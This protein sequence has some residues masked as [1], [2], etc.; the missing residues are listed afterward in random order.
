V[1]A[2]S[3][4]VSPTEVRAGFRPWRE[5][6]KRRLT[7]IL[8][9]VPAYDGP[10]S[11][12][13]ANHEGNV[14]QR[15]DGR[16]EARLSYVDNLTG[17][18]KRV[19]VYGASQ[20]GARDEL[21]KVR[22]RIAADAPVR[23]S[24]QGVAT[25]LLKWRT[26]TLAVSDRAPSTRSLYATLCK[27]HLEPEP[28]GSITL[29]R[30]RPTDIEAL[31][32][33]LR[34][35]GLSDSTIRSVYVVLRAAL[36]AAVRD[37]HLARN[38]AAL[39][40]R[41]AVEQRETV[42]LVADEVTALL[43]AA[44]GSRYHTALCLILSTGM[45]RGETLA[46]RWSDID[47][48]KGSAQIARTVSRVDGE[49]VFTPPKSK[50]ARRVP[51]SPGVVAMLKRHRT[52]QKQDRL[53]AGNQW[54]DAGLVFTTEVGTAV[55]PRNLLRVVQNAAKTAK[56]SGIGTHTLRHSAATAWLESGV[57]IKAV[58]DLL[59]HSSIAITGDVYGHTSDDTARAAV[60]GIDRLLGLGDTHSVQ[61][62]V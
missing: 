22:D 32:L 4:P 27:K 29:D 37:G 55:D 10:V 11:K 5:V 7:P 58:S 39:V 51:L 2:G 54:T 18:R 14:Y 59:G 47:L 28:F 35:N 19:S 17:K 40:Q 52:A 8:T 48:D 42:F 44:Q 49:L 30:L 41:P 12:R 13:R 15:G 24:K 56:L 1:V 26:T 61:P 45:R 53:R 20:K 38:P 60:A 16:W 36:D 9:P 50:R 34:E 3:N 57:H 62:L 43:R 33:T 6:Q 23:D 46:L 31:I 25:W 21:K